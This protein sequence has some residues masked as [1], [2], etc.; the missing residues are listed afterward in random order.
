MSNAL[1]ALVVKEIKSVIRDKMFLI[2][3]AITPLIFI[4]LG[5]LV[6]TSAEA[7]WAV[8]NMSILL[9][10]CDKGPPAQDLASFLKTQAAVREGGCM[11]VEKAI[12]E[13]GGERYT[14]VMYIPEDFSAKIQNG[15]QAVVKVYLLLGEINPV[16]LSKAYA[17][18]SMMSKFNNLLSAQFIQKLGGNPDVVLNPVESLQL[19]VYRDKVV[20]IGDLATLSV[21]SITPVAILIV[22]VFSLQIGATSL[23]LEKQE[24]T[25]ETLLTLPVGRVTILVSKLV[26]STLVALIGASTAILGFVYLISAV[27][28][29][30]ALDMLGAPPLYVSLP[31]LS[32]TVFLT[33]ILGFTLS[34]LVAIFT[35]DVRTAQSLVGLLA[36]PFALAAV[37][38]IIMSASPANPLVYIFLA[39]KAALLGQWAEYLVG[40]GYLLAFTLLLLLLVAKLFGSERLLAM[41]LSFRKRGAAAT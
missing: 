23:A 10:N 11:A 40:L 1:W 38:S 12:R 33:M 7:T 35:E 26:G 17:L 27:F 36:I 5:A 37:M 41:R 14:A 9:L 34:M 25:L 28:S 31:L 13:S 24:R 18:N 2:T 19:A 3:I 22:F 15:S 29:L 32:L 39:P 30:K 16:E 4:V 20:E 8:G 6:G 21:I